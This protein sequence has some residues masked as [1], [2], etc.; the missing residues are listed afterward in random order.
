M[1]HS[2]TDSRCPLCGGR[3]KPG[4]TTYSVDLG[5]GVIV[6]RNVPATVCD[7]CGEEWIG[8]DIAQKLEELTEEARQKGRQ[9]E[10]VAL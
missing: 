10:I 7:Q 1:K 9:V 2:A 3:K 6:V 5:T 8:S 4:T